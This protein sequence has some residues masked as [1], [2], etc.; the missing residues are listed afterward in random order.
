[1]GENNVS[2]K[3]VE[4][5]KFTKDAVF[6]RNVSKKTRLYNYFRGIF[7]SSRNELPV[8]GLFVRIKLDVIING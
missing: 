8:D 7:I 3:L 5:F 4:I 6:F 1:M 2:S